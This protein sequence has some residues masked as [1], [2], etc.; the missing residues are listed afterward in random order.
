MTNSLP[1]S[2][3]EEF[4]AAL[5]RCD[6]DTV[7]DYLADD[8]VWT[9]SGPVNILPFCG[10]RV[11]KTVVMQLLKRDIPTHLSRRGF[12]TNAILVDGDHAAILGKLTATKP[13]D[14]HSIS[15]RIAQFARFRDDKLIEYISIIDSFDAV[16]QV[17]GYPLAMHDGQKARE[18]DLIA[19]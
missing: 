18:G 15:Y 1:R 8:V 3:V 13:E 6:M 5:E 7:G 19:V 9:V 16:E 17:R 10:Q 12:I 11:G 4:Y 2:V 14:G